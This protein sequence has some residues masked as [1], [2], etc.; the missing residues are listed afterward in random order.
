[1]FYHTLYHFIAFS[2]T[3]LLTRCH[4][5]SCLFSAVF[6]FRKVTQ[7]IFSELDETKTEPPIL[8]TRTQ[9]PKGRRRGATRLP[10]HLAARVP[11]PAHGEVVWGPYDPPGV[12][13]TPIY[14]CSREKL[15]TDHYS[16]KSSIVAVI[17][18]PRSGGFWSSSQHPTG[19]EI[20]TRGLYITMPASGVMCE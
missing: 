16:T 8:P 9:N 11:P 12:S 6:G 10:H 18:N 14:T 17:I 19:G 2:G 4:S 13:P 20:I 3:N 5:A 15:K 7:E 1:M